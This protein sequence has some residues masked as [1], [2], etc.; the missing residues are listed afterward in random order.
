[1]QEEESSDAFERV[2]FRR[3]APWDSDTHEVLVGAPLGFVQMKPPLDLIC[4]V[5]RAMLC[6][7]CAAARFFNE[8][9]GSLLRCGVDRGDRPQQYTQCPLWRDWATRV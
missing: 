1:M 5:L 2:L 6:G 3:L 8:P 7:W 4:T 9:S